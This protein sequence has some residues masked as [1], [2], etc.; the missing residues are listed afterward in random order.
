MDVLNVLNVFKV[1][2]KRAREG[3]GP[4][5]RGTELPRDEHTFPVLIYKSC[6]V[7]NHT[8]A[9]LVFSYASGSSV[10]GSRET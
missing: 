2:F 3:D 9:L 10:P 7:Y 4:C 5:S 1:S 8:G 6:H